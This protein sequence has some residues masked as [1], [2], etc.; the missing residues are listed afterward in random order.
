[1]K[2]H[3]LDIALAI[4]VFVLALAL[5]VVAAR[6]IFAGDLRFTMGD[7]YQYYQIAMALTEGRGF[8]LDG[9]PTAY[10]MPLFPL[11]AAFWHMILGPRPYAPLPVFLVAS[12][13]IPVGVYILGRSLAGRGVALA[14]AALV[15]TDVSLIIYS[16]HY[17]TETLFSLLVLAGMLAAW[18]L[19][20][21]E[22]WRWAAGTG[23]L[24]GAAT[25][26]R[27]NF[28]PFVLLLGAWLLWHG[29]ARP[30]RGARNVAIVVGL[31]G[32]LWL[33]WAARNAAVFHS[34]IPFTTQAGNAYYGIYND[35]VAGGDPRI[36]YGYWVWRIPEPP[37]LP[38]KVWDE[39]ALDVY[40][41]D[42]A[43]AWIAANPTKALRVALMQPVYLWL[44]EGPGFES[45]A[46]TVLL[47]LPALVV[48]ALRR[49][50]PELVLWLGLA[51]TLTGLAVISVGVG[52]YNLPMRPI[53][54]V[55]SVMFVAG[56]VSPLVK[57]L[58][59]PGHRRVDEEGVLT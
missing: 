25:L 59:R 33:P 4:L 21:T 24:M 45:W 36:A 42:E 13:M 5:R 10:R 52:R 37:A 12:A 28:G 17:M 2:R 40:Q 20:V 41:R 43:R 3:R 26:T 48:F 15:A 54:A 8:A 6:H 55:T 9:L 53:L 44:P 50:Q 34:F 30:G 49:R 56:P 35:A 51:L 14:A 7:D 23:L 32:A 18:R 47:G 16:R 19:R 31:V 57:A 11:F 1:M 27:A 38:G 22:S 39:S 46:L 58:R 29:R